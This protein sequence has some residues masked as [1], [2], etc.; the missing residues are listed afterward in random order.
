VGF[1]VRSQGG[2]TPPSVEVREGVLALKPP[3]ASQAV[4]SVGSQ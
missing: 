1:L 4:W 2:W 3:G